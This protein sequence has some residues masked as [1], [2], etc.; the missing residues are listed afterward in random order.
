MA[1]SSQ[2]S[3]SY[4]S[5][6]IS[7]SSTQQHL[8]ISSL[9]SSIPNILTTLL[10]LITLSTSLLSTPVSAALTTVPRHKHSATYIN[11]TVYFVGGL[12]PASL[13]DTN[14]ATPVK[15]ISALDL[16]TLQFNETPTSLAIYNHAATSATVFSNSLEDS[17][18]IGISFGQ[19]AAN[20]PAVPLQWLDPITGSVNI[21]GK[22][23][24]TKGK[25]K[26]P[27]IGRSG[28]TLVQSGNNLWDFG[29]H[30]YPT[31]VAG[32][33]PV[34]DTPYFD[35]TDMVW[36]NQTKGLARYGHASATAGIDRILTCYGITIGDSL[37]DDCVYF[38][39]SSKTFSPA[40]LTWTNPEDA[41]TSGLVGHTIVTGI[42]NP[43]IL[44]MFGGTDVNGTIFSQGVY[45]LD[46]TKLPIITV[47][48]IVQ[49][50]DFNPSIIPD[51]RAGHAAVTVGTQIGVMIIHGGRS[52]SSNRS[53]IIMSDSTPYFFN[54]KNKM[55][56]DGETFLSMYLGQ[57]PEASVSTVVI[58]IG[59]L[60][61]TIVLGAGVAVY[62]WKGIRDDEIE[63]LKNE[64]EAAAGSPTLST[65]DDYSGR[66][67]GAERKSQMVY[68][69]GDDDVSL[70][71][72]PFKSTTSLIRPE[73][74][75]KKGN[76]KKGNRDYEPYSPG[77]T[78]LTETG[79]MSGYYSSTSSGINKSNSNGSSQ[80]SRQ[81]QQGGGRPGATPVNGGTGDSYY[82]SRD[83]YVEERSRAHDDDDSMSLTSESTV[84]HWPGPLDPPNPRFSRGAL[85]LAHR[86][87]VGA[88][89]TNG[90]RYSGG[91]DTS[92]PGGSLS[93]RDDEHHR[94]SVNSMQ[95][96]SFDPSELAA[97]AGR[98]ES[99]SLTVRNASMY[100]G[101][102]RG[103]VIQSSYTNYDGSNASDTNT[104][105]SGSY[106]SGP[107]GKRISTAL[108]AR[109]QRRSIQY[110]QDSQNSMSV[111]NPDSNVGGA[112][113]VTNEDPMVTKVLPIIT[114]K[115]TKPT[116]AKVVVNPHR[117]GSRTI[118]LP[119][120]GPLSER[121]G[122]GA[123]GG[124]AAGGLGID[125][126]RFDGSTSNRTNA[127]M[128]P[129]Q[130]RRGSSTLN[131]SYNK[132]NG[133]GNN[134]NSS[135]SGTATKRESRF[136][137]SFTADSSG[138]SRQGGGDAPNVVLRMPPPP[139][140]N[141]RNYGDD[142]QPISPVR[143]SIMVLG[144]DMPGFLNY[145]DNNN[146]N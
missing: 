36:Y 81:G 107:G 118:V 45:Q 28:H 21:D 140:H 134:N 72:G 99:G 12:G 97:A 124:D 55:W 47:T 73:D 109:Q 20:I 85:S 116:M 35:L 106:Y 133:S 7:T 65:M 137:S 3:S 38:S 15:A 59:I 22:T 58:I 16:K 130:G 143:D 146:T 100:G 39:V 2:G 93:S 71:N 19:T 11:D 83:L 43:N 18:K 41:I 30:S 66:K 87:L 120:G 44:F 78:T 121:R 9:F 129:Y 111:R 114:T 80:Y 94:R 102:N 49:Q 126:S 131:P 61:G 144:Q 90:N 5:I 13:I 75:G 57:K 125:F 110:S 6:S 79:S 31:S 74:N 115:I 26:T 141:N 108:A 113:S 145:G 136:A 142:N 119:N 132:N 51:S 24:I 29:G 48:K 37:K 101:N 54:M 95:W 33:V 25:K 67:G 70:T 56:I 4:S 8:S 76:K 123:E 1:E 88:I 86:Q 52:A 104:S 98:P 68:P 14:M 42:L 139:K 69:L 17:Y 64:A 77:G 10:L 50:S 135:M 112:S 46:T 53:R 91:W 127:N 27:V 32:A 103:S 40:E 62:I 23:I 128:A 84:S 138:Q 122:S 60:A 96:V 105:D 92:S 82:N 34:L 89:S 63:R 117:R